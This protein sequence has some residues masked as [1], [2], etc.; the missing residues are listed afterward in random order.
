[1]PSLKYLI[2]LLS[3]SIPSLRLVNSHLLPQPTCVQECIEQS[4]D[5][6]CSSDDIP[7]LCVSTENVLSSII[8]CIQTT[9]TNNLDT[10]TLLTP[11]QLACQLAGHPLPI[12]TTSAQTLS[13]TITITTIP[14]QTFLPPRSTSTGTL[15]I[16]T[17]PNPSSPQTTATTQASTLYPY[18]GTKPTSQAIGASTSSSA[19]TQLTGT[20]TSTQTG[21]GTGTGGEAVATVGSKTS[22]SVSST[23]IPPNSAETNG[24][25]FQD[26]S[27]SLGSCRGKGGWML[28]MGIVYLV[29]NFLL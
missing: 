18:L 2:T 13:G 20:R 3:I 29:G 19:V 16:T 12:P 27:S 17:I 24:S 28:S 25:P 5:I 22:T 11:L 8:S 23:S 26:G 1:M 21:T 4:P 15:I 7:C 9:C 14:T 10:T 6:K